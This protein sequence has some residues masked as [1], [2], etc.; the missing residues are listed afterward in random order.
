MEEDLSGQDTTNHTE[1]SMT[2][3]NKVDFDYQILSETPADKFMFR[4]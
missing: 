3:F 4:H 2:G 1:D